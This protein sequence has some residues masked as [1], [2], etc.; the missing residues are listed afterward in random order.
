MSNAS[1]L[2]LEFKAIQQR[3]LWGS[4]RGKFETADVVKLVDTL[5]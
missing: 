3:T 4:C 1:H 5:S 2:T